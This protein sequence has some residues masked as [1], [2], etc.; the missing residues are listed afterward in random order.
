M[1]SL[2]ELKSD[3]RKRLACLREKAEKSTQQIKTIRD[4]PKPKFQQKKE[5][6]SEEIVDYSNNNDARTFGTENKSIDGSQAPSLLS[7]KGHTV[8][9]I[10]HAIERDTLLKYKDKT[11]NLITNFYQDPNFLDVVK[12]NDSTSSKVT[13]DLKSKLSSELNILDQKTNRTIKQMVRRR[14][15]VSNESTQEF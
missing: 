4:I 15:I 12:S 7:Q 2:E 8:E 6:D 10:S 1:L 9:D 5:N 3:R 13:A 14:L 11:S